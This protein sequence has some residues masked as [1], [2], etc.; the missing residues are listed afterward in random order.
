VL[1]PLLVLL[2]GSAFAESADGEGG[3]RVFDTVTPLRDG[4]PIGDASAWRLVPPGIGAQYSPRGDLVLQNDHLTAVFAASTGRVTL[5]S[6]PDP[7]E[8]RVE[9][10]PMGT[11]G[12][13]AIIASCR[14]LWHTGDEAVIACTVSG[15]G[16][17]EDSRAIFSFT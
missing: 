11:T 5:Y 2:V 7:R 3:L 4:A 16:I 12:A 10:V 6:G 9:V 13:P 14:I 15:K 1:V 17:P 8:P